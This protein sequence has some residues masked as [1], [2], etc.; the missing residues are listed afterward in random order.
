VRARGSA[1]SSQ[2][3]LGRL[4][5]IPAKRYGPQ[6]VALTHTSVGDSAGHDLADV[7]VVLDHANLRETW[8]THTSTHAHIHSLSHC[9][10]LSLSLWSTSIWNGADASPEGARILETMWSSR[11]DMSAVPFEDMSRPCGKTLPRAAS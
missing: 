5:Y 8:A 11:T 1:G 10:I 7:R 2:R 4:A 3:H 9:L 6:N